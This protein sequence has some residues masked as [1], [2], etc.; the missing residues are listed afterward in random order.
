MNKTRVAGIAGATY[1]AMLSTLR[2]GS[3]SAGVSAKRRFA[4][5]KTGNC[6]CKQ[7]GATTDANSHI[8]PEGDWICPGPNRN[9]STWRPSDERCAAGSLGITPASACDALLQFGE[10]LFAGDSI[11]RQFF[12]GLL[13]LLTGDWQSGSL[14]NA[15]LGDHN[16][17]WNNT[18]W[19]RWWP[20]GG[21]RRNSNPLCQG[22]VEQFA[23]GCRMNVVL[24]TTRL[25]RICGGRLK[26]RFWHSWCSAAGFDPLLSV[27]IR[28]LAPNSLVVTNTGM[29]PGFSPA[30][31]TNWLS[32]IL[33]R[34]PPGTHV[35][36][37]A[38]DPPGA[39]K[40]EHFRKTQGRD[41]LRA[42]LR[43]NVE[44]IARLR[45]QFPRQA[46]DLIGFW[47][48][49]DKANTQCAGDA[50]LPSTDGTHYPLSVN[51]EKARWLMLL[52]KEKCAETRLQNR[53]LNASLSMS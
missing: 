42:A 36:W 3:M 16:Y 11:S 49:T 27:A 14:W 47:N 21:E 39:K 40:P 46:L 4:K 41:A 31:M 52:I 25:E 1:I 33:G 9:V 38:N 8:Y 32:P 51:V 13:V 7:N 17:Q 22:R 43:D 53:V 12:Q 10:V 6:F 48:M 19:H 15:T 37:H 35:V 18:N 28:N 50:T 44:W 30:V 34:A 20:A 24:D 26:M 23:E 2:P 5:F 29:H 45:S